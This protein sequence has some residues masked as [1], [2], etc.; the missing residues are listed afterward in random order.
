MRDYAAVRENLRSPAYCNAVRSYLY[1]AD[2]ALKQLR[3]LRTL[4][5]PAK[6]SRQKL[7][8][9]GSIIQGGLNNALQLI[10]YPMNDH[11][12]VHDYLTTIDGCIM[13]F[14]KWIFEEGLR[15]DENLLDYHFYDTDICLQTIERGYKVATIDI[16]AYHYSIGQPPKNF[17]DL[18]KVFLEKWD[19]KVNSQW[20]ISR[21]TKFK[22]NSARNLTHL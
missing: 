5:N 19:K 15:F 14:P 10:E 4:V 8:G 9:S 17:E 20:P 11:P 18:K 2:Y 1:E 16:I 13:F 21:I 22:E 3:I 6:F 12:G 7:Y